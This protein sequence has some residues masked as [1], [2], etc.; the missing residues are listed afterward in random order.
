VEDMQ[1]VIIQHGRYFSTYSNLSGV[2]VSRGQ[3]VKTGQVIGRVA[4]NLD[5]VGSVDL[6]ISNENSNFY[7]PESWLRRR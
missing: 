1:V 4:V 5:G 7:D 6:Y 2:S 3:Q